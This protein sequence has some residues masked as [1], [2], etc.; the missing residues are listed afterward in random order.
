MVVSFILAVRCVEDRREGENMTSVGSRS[1]CVSSQ[2]RRL[3][4]SSLASQVRAIGIIYLRTYS[5]RAIGLLA[6]L[7]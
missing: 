5:L 4:S 2:L 7:I 6:D 3:G 1:T